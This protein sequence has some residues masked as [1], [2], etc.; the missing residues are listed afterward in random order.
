MHVRKWLSMMAVALALVPVLP[1]N[2]QAGPDPAAVQALRDNLRADRK[3]VVER[4][5]QLT[6]AEAAKFWP[7][8][9]AFQKELAPIRSRYNRAILDFVGTE[10]MTDANAKRIADQVLAADESDAK[11]RRSYASK[12]NK[13]VGAKKAARYLQIENKI[14]ALERFD[15]AAA[16]PLV[17]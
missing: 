7:V 15:Q 13:A 3:A 11:L 14:R 2:A 4:N 6:S 5:M 9:D 8:Y 12:F 17:P 1:A 16:I 10:T